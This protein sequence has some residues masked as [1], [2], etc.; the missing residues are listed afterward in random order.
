MSIFS[1]MYL[2]FPAACASTNERKFVFVVFRFAPPA[3]LLF[4]TAFTPIASDVAGQP[5]AR[6]DR[7]P[8]HL[9]AF[10]QRKALF[11]F[12]RYFV[13]SRLTPS[14]VSA[15]VQSVRETGPITT[16]FGASALPVLNAKLE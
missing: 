15:D 1:E 14:S 10:V 5:A 4:T 7:S 9:A 8:G 16:S 11:V 2:D 3:I 6:S 13:S 12:V